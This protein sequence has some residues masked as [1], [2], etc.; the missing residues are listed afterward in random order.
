VVSEVH[1]GIEQRWRLDRRLLKAACAAGGVVEHEADEGL[2]VVD[3]VGG[4][5]DE[6]FGERE[7]ED[8][9]VLVWFGGCGALAD[10]AGQVDLHPLAEETGAG[11]VFCQE[12]PTFGAVASFFDQLAF[13]S[14]EGGFLGF[15]AA[16]R[17]LD[18]E[19]TG[20]VTVL[21]LEDDV[22]VVGVF[23]L[24]DGKDD[25]GT[26]MA[27]DVADVDIAARFFHFVAEDG[28]DLSLVGEFGGDKPW[29][30]GACFLCG[31][32]GGAGFLYYLGSHRAKVSSCI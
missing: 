2:A 24:I 4:D 32:F 29:F 31:G 16:R 30:C 27:N 19:L 23:G 11:E 12:G 13:G 15:D 26:I 5:E 21:T 7:A 17:K 10:V 8:F 6:S 22:G 9:D 20:G 1:R 3:L 28:E 14:R 18:E 25:N